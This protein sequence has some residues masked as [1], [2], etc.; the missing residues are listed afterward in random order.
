MF[1]VRWGGFTQFPAVVRGTAL[2]LYSEPMPGTLHLRGDGVWWVAEGTEE[3]VNLSGYPD[4]SPVTGASVPRE[5]TFGVMLSPTT[6]RVLL[7]AGGWVELTVRRRSVERVRRAL[8]RRTAAAGAPAAGPR[9]AARDPIGPRAVPLLGSALLLGRVVV[10]P[11]RSV[12]LLMLTLAWFLIDR[13]SRMGKRLDELVLRNRYSRRANDVTPAPNG[14]TIASA[15]AGVPGTGPLAVPRTFEPI[16]ATLA[17]RCAEWASRDSVDPHSWLQALRHRLLW[18]ALLW[19]VMGVMIGVVGAGIGS[20]V[21][22]LLFVVFGTHYLLELGGTLGLDRI[23]RWALVASVAVMLIADLC[24]VRFL[25]RARRLAGQS[26]AHRARYLLARDGADTDHLILF[27]LFGDVSPIGVIELELATAG[28]IPPGGIV[29]L[30]GQ[31]DPATGRPA[32]GALIVPMLDSGPLWPA[33]NF[34]VMGDDELLELVTGED[35]EDLDEVKAS[36][37]GARR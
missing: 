28:A 19:L 32:V 11:P 33:E 31:T 16:R 7:D 3:P 12:S 21:D 10:D 24:A 15:P 27:P 13:G 26:P 8:N 18:R 34:N 29:E 17:A 20:V 36:A 37:A 22:D 2:G 35:P 6:L 30:A 4:P 5:L 9:R 25:V 1:G 14:F 23:L